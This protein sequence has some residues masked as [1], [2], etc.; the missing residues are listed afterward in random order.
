LV[1]GNPSFVDHLA[2]CEKG[3]WDKGGD[4]SGIRID[5]DDAT[6]ELP[7]P[8]L[9]VVGASAE[10]APNQQGIPPG[11]VGLVDG[12]NGFADRLAKFLARKDLM[13]R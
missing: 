2:I 8:S 13:V 1:E 12:I 3:V 11:L 6:S 4:P 10:P 9:P 7:V 5:N